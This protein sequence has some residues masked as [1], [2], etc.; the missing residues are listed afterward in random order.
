[1]R[2]KSRSHRRRGPGRGTGPW[3]AVIPDGSP[4]L[5][6]GLRALYDEMRDP[7]GHVDHILTVHS[8]HPP[9]LAVHRDFYRLVMYGPSPLTRIQR[10]M[11]AVTVSAINRCHY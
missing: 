7:R 11:I 5:D 6:P 2:T 8:L 9:S 10:E 4:D 3:I 1:M